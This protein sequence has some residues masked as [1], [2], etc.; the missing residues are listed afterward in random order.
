MKTD[1]A[2]Y[3]FLSAG[4][5]AFRVLTAGLTLVGTYSFGSLTTN[6][7]AAMPPSRT[8]PVSRHS[9]GMS[10]TNKREIAGAPE[11]I[12]AGPP[13]RRTCL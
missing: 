10:A 4:P 7:S 5:E 13:D 6:A 3:E 2:I 12:T 9:S 1:Q 8:R 11:Q